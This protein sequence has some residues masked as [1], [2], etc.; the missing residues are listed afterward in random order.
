MKTLT[1]KT[2]YAFLM[3]VVILF[4]AVFSALSYAWL[5]NYKKSGNFDFKSG[6]L[7]D[8]TLEIAKIVI[9]DPT[10]SE[11]DKETSRAFTEIKNF[12]IE[13]NADG[14]NFEAQLSNM[15][16]GTIDNVAQLKNENRVYFRLTVPKGLGDT[17]KLNLHYNSENFIKLYKNIYDGDTITGTEEVTDSQKLS[18]L[19]AVEGETFAND[20]F[21]LYNAAAS[22]KKLAANQIK[23]EFSEEKTDTD[24]NPIPPI[25]TETNQK[26][27]SSIT[28]YTDAV[29]GNNANGAI[30]TVTNADYDGTDW[31]V[32]MEVT[33]NLGVFAYSIEYIS[34]IMPCYMF[35]NIG[36]N[37]ESGKIPAQT[38]PSAN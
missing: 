20:R 21:L 13:A 4:T 33:P 19:I 26:K 25:F 17:V 27:I 1:R 8:Y 36:M 18:A 22:N 38:T 15:S 37:I 10:M 12:K 3:A 16:F 5:V 34:D 32:Y 28:E 14:T 29:N 31:Y 24:G 2:L 30:L 35:F 11:E 6:E 9:T 7:P 23:A